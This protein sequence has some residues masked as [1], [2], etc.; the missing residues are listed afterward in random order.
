MEK[1][2][3][4]F[5]PISIWGFG[6]EV[7]FK[8]FLDEIPEKEGEANNVDTIPDLAWQFSR[9]TLF[10]FAQKNETSTAML[11]NEPIPEIEVTEDSKE[12]ITDTE[13]KEHNENGETE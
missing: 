8:E 13:D 4:K 5:N 9:N 1:E 12:E 6:D 3:F 11:S 7:A 10:S 2:T